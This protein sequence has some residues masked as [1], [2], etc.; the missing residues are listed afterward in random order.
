MAQVRPAVPVAQEFLEALACRA[1]QQHPA[2][3]QVLEVRGCLAV[4]LRLA[5]LK[6][7]S[8][9]RKDPSR[10]FSHTLPKSKLTG[11]STAAL[12]L[13]DGKSEAIV[14]DA[15]LAGFGLRL[16]EGG[17]RTWIFQY[18]IGA[19]HRRIT[20]GSYPALTP[21]QARRVAA[22]LHAKV[23]LGQDPAGEKEQGRKR[24]AET[25]AAILHTYLEAKR[26]ALRPRSY[27]QI[28][29]HLLTH[30]MPLHRLQVAKIDRRSIAGLI[31]NLSNSSG[32]VA[33]N[34]TRASLSAF[35]AWAIRQGLI[36]NNPVVGIGRHEEQSRDRVLS[37][38]EIAAIWRALDDDHYGAIVKLLLLTGQRAM[39]IAGLQ[40][41]EIFDTQIVQPKERTKNGRMHIV[42]LSAPAR[43]ILVSQPRR[44]R[45]LIFGIGKGPFSGWSNSKE[46][47]D[48]RIAEMT[49]SPLPHWTHH[50]LRRTAATRMA[51][52]G[53]QPHIIEAVLNHVSGHKSGVHGI[54]NLS[55]YESEKKAALDRWADHVLATVT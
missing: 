52:I 7:H 16:R 3:Q 19:K 30:A 35:F 37:V 17:A 40:W 51:E 34:R 18:K 48:G 25:F 2:A 45:E 13:P 22:E 21:E 44:D 24:A 33:A 23:R 4:Q 20:F 5:A 46:R 27:D 31:G 50:D 42:P 54:Y 1:D 6:V 9:S 32:L 11:R 10:C 38:A 55:T 26:K 53:I 36:D 39:E 28:S 41:S 15:D 29:C 47:L 8:G 12:S 49:G 43:S 14:F